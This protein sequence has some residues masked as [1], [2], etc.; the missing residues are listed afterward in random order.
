MDIS[1]LQT[2][3][4]RRQEETASIDAPPAAAL[5]AT[6]DRAEAPGQGDPLPPLWHWIY[7]TPRARQSELGVDGHPRLGGFMPPIPLPRRMWAGSRLRFGAPILVGDTVSRESE[8]TDVAHKSGRQGDLVFV[9]LRHR[10]QNDRGMLIE[11]EQ[12]LVYRAPSPAAGA[13]PAVVVERRPAAWR[14][15]LTPDPVL[16]FRYSAVTFNAHRI[17][18]D[19]PYAKTEEGYPGLVVHG[20]LTATLLASS[21]LANA[22]GRLAEFSFRGQRPLFADQPMFLCGQPGAAP[23]QYDLWAENAD[24]EIAM[25]ATARLE[26]Q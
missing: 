25:S 18:Y 7:F 11:E 22:R 3:I 23:G 21:L 20:P 5:A 8:I 4:G 1:L 13:A 16:L 2:W 12:D 26:Q 15:A 10:L 24:G 19:A 9:T 14:E 17:H 6:L